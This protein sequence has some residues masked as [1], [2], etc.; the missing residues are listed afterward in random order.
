LL[1]LFSAALS[2]TASYVGM[3]HFGV[4]GALLG[5]LLGELINVTGI[6]LF[7]LRGSEPPREVPEPNPVTAA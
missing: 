5:I 2:L 7:S 1:T 4:S 3:L 6:V